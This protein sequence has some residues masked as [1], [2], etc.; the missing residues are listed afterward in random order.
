MKLNHINYFSSPMSKK[1]ILV[2]GGAGY[3]GSHTI[4]E[5]LEEGLWNVVSA[6]NFCNSTPKTFDRIEHITGKRIKNYNID[7]TD[8]KATREI[9]EKESLMAVIHFAA[10]KSV[11][12]SVD[13]PERY[14]HNNMGSLQNILEL[15]VEYG[16]NIH[17]FSSSC[18]VYGNISQLPVT[19]NTPLPKAESPYGETKQ[20]GEL[21]VKQF[22]DNN[23]SL[24]AVALR[25]FNPVGAHDSGL[26]G[27]DPGYGT[28]NLVPVICQLA[29]GKRD[30]IIVHGGDYNTKDGTCIRDYIH[31]SDIAVAHILAIKYALSGEMKPGFEIF[32]LGYGQGISVLELI[33]TFEEVNNLKLNWEMG[34]R[35]PGDAEAIYSDSS[36]A[37]QLLGWKPMHNLKNMMKT[38]WTWEQNQGKGY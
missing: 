29:I 26:I 3:I 27:E 22:C 13:Q 23:V 4:L 6:D 36:K 37:E 2:T 32:N 17:V 7:L 11:G 19:E 30:K 18:S 31:V 14:F 38:A 1:T 34:P 33:K 25:Y 8:K 12:E 24:R 28:Q 20:K 9:F 16:V 10:L 35:R 21:L 5:I 15:Q